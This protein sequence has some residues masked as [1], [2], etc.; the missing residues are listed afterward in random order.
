M[1]T[2][3]V[4]TRAFS[5]LLCYS[6]V[7]LLSTFIQSLQYECEWFYKLPAWFDVPFKVSEQIQ[8]SVGLDVNL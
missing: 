1:H 8:M 4:Q 7:A 5:A 6:H 2:R 3:V